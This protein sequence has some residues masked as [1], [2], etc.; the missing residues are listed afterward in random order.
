MATPKPPFDRLTFEQREIFEA[1]EQ[2][3]RRIEE[4]RSR[5][6]LQVQMK[7][8]ASPVTSA[9]LAAHE[10]FAKLNWSHLISEEALTRPT[11]K[12]C[13]ET[14]RENFWLIDPLDGTRDLIRGEL[15]F[16]IVAGELR[17]RDDGHYQPEFGLIWH[18]PTD[19]VWL[20]WVQAQEL[21]SRRDGIWAKQSRLHLPKQWRVLGSRGMP[22]ER[23]QALSTHL[24]LGDNPPV[25]RLGSALKFA[26]LAM[27]DA[28]VYPR[29]GP[30]SEWDTAAGQALLEAAGGG[31]WDLATQKRLTYFKSDWENRGGFLALRSQE[32]ASEIVTEAAR[33]KVERDRARER[34]R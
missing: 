19:E 27:G 11:P 10:V 2:A 25:E 12:E 18:P 14:Q 6:D 24:G 13:L 31:L 8:D 33:I 28:E 9:D 7:S 16:A 17:R 15:S 32:R 26:R 34:N 5:G 3:A 23:L 29:F 4:V 20:G 1:A 30:T 21:W 22:L